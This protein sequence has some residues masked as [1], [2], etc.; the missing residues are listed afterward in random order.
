MK[1]EI[2][3]LLIFLIFNL[4]FAKQNLLGEPLRVLRTLAS[5]YPLHHPHRLRLLRVVPLLSLSLARF[6]RNKNA[7]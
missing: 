4:N 7:N 3:W 2:I 1:Y 6:A 5:G